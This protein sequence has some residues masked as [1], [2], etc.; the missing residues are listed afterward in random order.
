MESDLDYILTVTEGGACVGSELIEQR[1]GR[2]KIIP[3]PVSEK[4]SKWNKWDFSSLFF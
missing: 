3:E 2:Q 4:T 1:V